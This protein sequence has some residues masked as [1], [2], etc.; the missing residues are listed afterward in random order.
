GDTS[1]TQTV[2]VRDRDTGQRER[3]PATGVWKRRRATLWEQRRGAAG[4]KGAAPSGSEIALNNGT[5]VVVEWPDVSI[6][7][8]AQSRR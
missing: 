6:R 3:I 5:R 8:V 7:R 4:S 1:S 2:T